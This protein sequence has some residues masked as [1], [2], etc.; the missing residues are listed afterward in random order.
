MLQ[1]FF[2]KHP[3]KLAGDNLLE[4]LKKLAILFGMNILKKLNR[5]SDP[6]Q[7]IKDVLTIYY[8]AKSVPQSSLLIYKIALHFEEKKRY[9][10]ALELYTQLY[11]NNWRGQLAPL[12]LYRRSETLRKLKQPKEAIRSFA[13]LAQRYPSHP[14]ASRALYNAYQLAV[15]LKDQPLAKKYYF[16]LL[17]RYPASLEAKRL[18]AG[19]RR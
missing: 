2:R 3:K 7:L 18:K 16:L 14:I 8:F 4:R 11:E 12:A 15:Q 10:K 19:L 17:R 5:Y 1:E 13:V 6:E 9:R